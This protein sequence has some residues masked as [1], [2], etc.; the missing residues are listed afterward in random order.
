M[1]R[2]TGPC[3]L[4]AALARAGAASEAPAAARAQ[5]SCHQSCIPVRTRS[6]PSDVFRLLPLLPS[7]F[8]LLQP[9]PALTHLSRLSRPPVADEVISEYGERGGSRARCPHHAHVH[10]RSLEYAPPHRGSGGLGPR[11]TPY[12]YSTA[13]PCPLSTLGIF[14]PPPFGLDTCICGTCARRR[15]VGWLV[16]WYRYCALPTRACV[17]R[18]VRCGSPGAGAEAGAAAASTPYSA[19]PTA[20]SLRSRGSRAVEPPSRR[21]GGRPAAAARASRRRTRLRMG[22]GVYSLSRSYLR[23]RSHW[24]SRS[25][26]VDCGRPRRARGHAYIRTWKRT[27][28]PRRGA[29][30]RGRA[31]VPNPM[32]RW[33][34]RRWGEGGTRPHTHAERERE[35]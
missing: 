9:L 18:S 11:A 16:G 12:V 17:R 4:E 2:R 3:G 35:R 21:P 31:I 34:A 15:L 27:R 30:V 19:T 22:G 26:A 13:C 25:R 23:S 20:V 6:S 7:L 5:G 14:P 29:N 10:A 24:R 33:S 32:D 8:V 28:P 1:L